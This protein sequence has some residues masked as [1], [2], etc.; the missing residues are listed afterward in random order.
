MNKKKK[1]KKFRVQILEEVSVSAIVEAS[2]EDEAMEKVDAGD[3]ER[4]PD[5]NQELQ[6]FSAVSAEAL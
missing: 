1:L 5:V 6:S 4:E 2:S 3:Y